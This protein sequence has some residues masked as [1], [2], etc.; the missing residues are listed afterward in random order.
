MWIGD[1]VGQYTQE[2]KGFRQ[3]R[4]F[5]L[6]S[7]SA[8]KMI[9]PT[10][11]RAGRL[12][13]LIATAAAPAIPAEPVNLLQQ[14]NAEYRAHRPAEAVQ[15]YERYLTQYEERA[16]VRVFLG[17]ALLNLNRRAEA[18]DQAQRALALDTNCWKAYTLA[19]RIYGSQLEWDKAHQ[20]YEA[21]LRLNPLDRETWYFFGRGYYEESRF[22]Q[23]IQAFRRAIELGALSGRV[24]ENLAL[25]YEALTRFEEAEAAYRRAIAL[26][27]TEFHP[28]HAY[29]VF[30]NKQGRSAESIRM[31]KKA[32]GL[33][34]E[35]VETRFELGK[36]LYQS[37]QLDEAATTIEG[38][39][40]LSD[41]CRIRN[42]MA[43]IFSMQL[44][45]V[46]A[47]TQVKALG[48]CRE[49]PH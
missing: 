43:R 38:A 9:V 21:A 47:E 14:A 27:D 34:P 48:A 26:T 13:V 42:L 6:T 25:S 18:L 22:E 4:T 29:G 11:M 5:L 37:G 19:G 45:T 41:Q 24:Y 8:C 30:L 20:A 16:D 3:N 2:E 15:L 17:G 28:Y 49:Q 7:T 44:K 39:L 36:T 10:H 46:E 23:A 35:A 40:A 12:L 1:G 31:L 33:N 32:V